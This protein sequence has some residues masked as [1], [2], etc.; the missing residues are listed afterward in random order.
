MRH[1]MPGL[2]GPVTTR[3]ARVGRRREAA[4]VCR[5]CGVL[6]SAL[7]LTSELGW[8]CSGCR[9]IWLREQ[10]DARPPCRPEPKEVSHAH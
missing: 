7:F 4:M 10:R 6:T 9:R 3:L 8:V 2:T 1:E 5:Q